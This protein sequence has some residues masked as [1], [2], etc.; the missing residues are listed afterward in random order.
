MV[1]L[2]NGQAKEEVLANADTGEVMIH[3]W[4]RNLKS[5][6]PIEK[7]P[8]VICSGDQTVELQPHPTPSD[9]PGFCSRFYGQADWFRGG[10]I[11]HGWLSSCEARSR[12]GVRLEQ[13]LEKVTEPTVRCGTKWVSIGGG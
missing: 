2:S 13:L 4:D 3:T 1:A 5:S 12:Q 6:Q 7:K 11:H 10:Q 9:P 8:L